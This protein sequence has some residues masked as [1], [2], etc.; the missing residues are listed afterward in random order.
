M[1]GLKAIHDTGIAH[2]DLKPENVLLDADFDI[3][4]AD[5]GFA[6]PI[7]GKNGDGFLRTRLGTKNHM[8]PDIHLKKP[9]KGEL[10]DLFAS[11]IIL[12]TMVS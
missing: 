8:A 4:V 11:A 3:K 2:R 9:Y 7:K 12:F 5:F 1:S 10:V 6:A